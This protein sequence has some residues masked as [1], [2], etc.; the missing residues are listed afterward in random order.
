MAQLSVLANCP[1]KYCAT[2]LGVLAAIGFLTM[3]DAQ[4][5]PLETTMT[6]ETVKQ[7]A[8]LGEPVREGDL[9]ANRGSGLDAPAHD[10]SAPSSGGFA[11]ILWDEPGQGKLGGVSGTSTGHVTVN[12]TVISK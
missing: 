3:V 4:A 12:G 6:A 9:R 2:V 7:V 5:S 10:A 1:R 11:V 8:M